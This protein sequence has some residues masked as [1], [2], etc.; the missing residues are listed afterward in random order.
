[1]L[2]PVSAIIFF[3]LIIAFV[4]YALG[5][6]NGEERANKKYQEALKERAEFLE[7][8]GYDPTPRHDPLKPKDSN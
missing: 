3:G 2:F 1:M 6:T 7:S 5:F 8:H 4:A